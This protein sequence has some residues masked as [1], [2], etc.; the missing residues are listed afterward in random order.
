MTAVI[1]DAIRSPM[2]RGRQGGGLCGVHPVELLATV[3]KALVARNGI[4]PGRID[5]VIIGCVSQVGE[6]AATGRA[7]VLAAGFPQHVPATT[8]DRKCGSSQQAI[9]FAAQGVASGAYDI[10]IAGGVESM[11]RVPMGSARLDRDPYGP[12]VNTR[13]QP[14]LVSQGIAAELV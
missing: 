11:S 5:D 13:Y 6:Q 2:G 8:I 4:D 12:S 3:L 7:A 10:V 9:H 14:G 1:V